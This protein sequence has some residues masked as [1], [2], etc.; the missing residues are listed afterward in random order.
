M[1]GN[2]INFLSMAVANSKDSFDEELPQWASD[3]EY[4]WVKDRVTIDALEIQFNLSR[5]SIFRIL[6]EDG[7]LIDRSKNPV[8]V[9]RRMAE[10]ALWNYCWDS[11]RIYRRW[12]R[13][14]FEPE[15][16]TEC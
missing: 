16:K 2:L 7:F 4:D 3:P 9:I 1:F 5:R 15:L 6:E 8:T 13:E 12:W 10:T 11:P 14:G